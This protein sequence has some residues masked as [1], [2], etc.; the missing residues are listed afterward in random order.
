MPERLVQTMKKVLV[1]GI[2]ENPGGVE[3]LIMNYYRHMDRERIQFDFLCN[4]EVVAYEDEIKSLGGRVFRVPA[5]RDNRKAFVRALDGFMKQYAAQYQTIWV[6][7]CSLANIDYL[8]YAKKYGIPK[9][10]I[11]CHNADNGD[12]FLRGLLH[13]RN[14]RAVRGYATDFWTCSD[15]AVDWFFGSDIRK[16]ASYRVIHNAVDLETYAYREEIRGEYRKKLGI[17]D[18]KVI[19]HIGRFHFQK[20]HAYLAEVFQQV[21]KKEPSACLLL[22]GQGD[23]MET[24]KD[25]VRE[26]G[27]EEQ[28]LFLGVRQD[29]ACLYQAMDCFVLPSVFE[30]VPLVGVEAQAAGLPCVFS[31]CITREL[32]LGNNIAFLPLD[33]KEKWVK[34]ILTA[35]KMSRVDNTGGLKANGYDIMTEAKK[36]AGLL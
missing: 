18:K 16:E 7:V 25:K 33:Q 13:K 12:S 26:L 28:V 20:N 4:T 34:A 6:N 8:K 22:I 24:I 30:G 21:L 15:Q 1:F 29:I 36:M 19:G 14:R 35:F 17:E 31:D 3:S 27:V 23:L 5:R 32:A 2:T 10:I 9:R 11:H